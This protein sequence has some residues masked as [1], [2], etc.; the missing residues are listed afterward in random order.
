LVL[1]VEQSQLRA[2]SYRD[3]VIEY[4]QCIAVLSILLR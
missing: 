4:S 3:A 1:A 2:G